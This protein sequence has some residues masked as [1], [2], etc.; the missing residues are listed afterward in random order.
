ME[1]KI[2]EVLKK[3]LEDIRMDDEK[4]ISL[5]KEDKTNLIEVFSLDS[6]LRVQAVIELEEAFGIEIDMEEIDMEIFEE[7]GRLK[8]MIQGYL[9]GDNE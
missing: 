7:S 5:I 2:L 8:K 3:V 9:S 6:Y 4:A 1:Q